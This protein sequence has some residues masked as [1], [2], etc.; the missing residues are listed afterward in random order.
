M[1]QNHY[2]INTLNAMTTEAGKLLSIESGQF[3]P[4]H[5]YLEANHDMLKALVEEVGALRQELSELKASK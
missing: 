3:Y 5:P 1:Q 2:L 4:L